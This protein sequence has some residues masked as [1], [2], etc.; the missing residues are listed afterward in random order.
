[1]DETSTHLNIKASQV[2]RPG[3]VVVATGLE[4]VVSLRSVNF[5]MVASPRYRLRRSLAQ[6][7]SASLFR[8][9]GALGSGAPSMFHIFGITLSIPDPCQ[10][11]T[12]R[13]GWYLFGGRNRTRTCGLA[14]LGQLRN[15]R[16]AALPLA[17]LSCSV[18]LRLAASRTAG[19]RLRCPIDVNDVLYPCA[20]CT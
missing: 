20:Q 16:L 3:I 13:S 5:A 4:P 10:R 11:K 12:T 6:Y 17:T 9:L 14:S 7:T 15:G 1:M 2:F 8:P 18:R 19:A